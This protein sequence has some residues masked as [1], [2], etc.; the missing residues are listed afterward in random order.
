MGIREVLFELQSTVSNKW[1]ARPTRMQ[2]WQSTSV[3]SWNRR[4]RW[5]RVCCCCEIAGAMR[6]SILELE[7]LVMPDGCHKRAADLFSI[8]LLNGLQRP[9]PL[10][11]TFLGTPLLPGTELLASRLAPRKARYATS[12]Q[13]TLFEGPASLRCFWEWRC[14]SK[15]LWSNEMRTRCDGP[16]RFAAGSRVRNFNAVFNFF[17]QPGQLIEK[18]EFRFSTIL[19]SQASWSKKLKCPR[20]QFRVRVNRIIIALK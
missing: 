15:C 10:T 19:I 13:A 6:P 11:V 16:L 2:S 20:L 3:M 8:T 4:C 9:T 12:H 14:R 17:N 18:I 5:A 1:P 7:S